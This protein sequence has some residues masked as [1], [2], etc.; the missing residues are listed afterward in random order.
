M[1][2]LS[3]ENA[4]RFGWSGDERHR[5]GS[6][7]DISDLDVSANNESCEAADGEGGLVR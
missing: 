1:E 6:R 7:T 5:S 2:I 4:D 3:S